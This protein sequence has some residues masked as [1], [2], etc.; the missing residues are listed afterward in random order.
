MTCIPGRVEF[1]SLSP[2]EGSL[3]RIGLKEKVGFQLFVELREEWDK[4]VVGLSRP[5]L[6]SE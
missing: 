2:G 6:G 3:G 1:Q 4:R 5:T